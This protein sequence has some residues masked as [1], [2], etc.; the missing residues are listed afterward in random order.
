MKWDAEK[1]DRVN[2]Q[3][4][5]SGIELTR[6]A[7][8]RKD[9]LILD[10]GCGTGR[11]TAELASLTP[12]GNVIGIDPSIEMINRATDRC[13]D[14]KN[15]T[16]H[17]IPAQS[18]TFT[19]TFDLVYSNLALQWVKERHKVAGLIYQALKPDGR[20]AFQIPGRNFCPN[21]FDCIHNT[22][23]DMGIE[24]LNRNMHETW[25]L[26]GKKEYEIFL[27]II[28]FNNVHADYKE[29]TL[30][31]RS[32]EEVADW[33]S[34]ALIPFMEPLDEK[35]RARFRDVFAIHSEKYRN[36]KGIKFNLNR[37]FAF[38]EK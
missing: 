37:I 15:V 26:P 36:E 31:F 6:L 19:D 4:F 5:E 22:T 9:D 11:I 18:M 14:I 20:I 27:R 10:L 29:Y 25:Y 12:K 7:D 8:V 13:R 32:T 35:S 3:Q 16:F 30:Y 21:L 1:Y 38:G 2:I 28:G 33:W 17:N 24:K 34:P 23:H